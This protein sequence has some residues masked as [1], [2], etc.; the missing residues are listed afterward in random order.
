MTFDLPNTT[1][2]P[3]SIE[4]AKELKKDEKVSTSLSNT[5]LVRMMSKK[6]LEEIKDLL[7]I[8]RFIFIKTIL[9]LALT[10]VLLC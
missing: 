7:A 4:E 1:N 3:I 2:D 6:T 5:Q 9:I 8:G 10:Y